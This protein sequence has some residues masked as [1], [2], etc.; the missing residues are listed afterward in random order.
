[1]QICSAIADNDRLLYCDH[2]PE[3]PNTAVFLLLISRLHLESDL[4]AAT[5]PPMGAN[6]IY[7][8]KIKE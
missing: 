6:S 1:L 2:L 8:G 3:M 4:V 5:K 7:V